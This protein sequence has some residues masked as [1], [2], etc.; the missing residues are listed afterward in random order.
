MKDHRIYK[1]G[2]AIKLLSEI[3]QISN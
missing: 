3:P 1:I 2:A